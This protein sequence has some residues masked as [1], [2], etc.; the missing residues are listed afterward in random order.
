[1]FATSSITYLWSFS[2][3]CIYRYLPVE[4]ML[5]L[6][7]EYDV[8]FLTQV[9]YYRLR[10]CWILL[11]A[12]FAYFCYMLIFILSYALFYVGVDICWFFRN[13][14]LSFDMHISHTCY[15]VLAFSFFYFW[16]S[17]LPCELRQNF[18]CGKGEYADMFLTNVRRLHE[19]VSRSIS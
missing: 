17:L 1:M 5:L 18:L 2:G 14:P 13:Y 4:V 12:Y 19:G 7:S 3:V 16:S 6:P 15:H 8:H 11:F 9:I 10:F